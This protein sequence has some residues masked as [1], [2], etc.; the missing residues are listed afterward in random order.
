MCNILD[1]TTF[2]LKGGYYLFDQWGCKV[3]LEADII[4]PVLLF[5]KRFDVIHIGKLK[6]N[7][8]LNQKKERN[9]AQLF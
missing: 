8:F 7:L 5:S 4:N 1:R 9:N 6:F 3:K 2:F